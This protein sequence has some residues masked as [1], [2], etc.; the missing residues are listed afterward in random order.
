MPDKPNFQSKIK[1]PHVC[2]F[3]CERADIP[4]ERQQVNEQPVNPRAPS[5]CLQP[6]QTSILLVWSSAAPG[7]VPDRH[8]RKSTEKQPPL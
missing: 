4:D 6:E 8:L 5:L 2:L 1:E 7:D 3:W